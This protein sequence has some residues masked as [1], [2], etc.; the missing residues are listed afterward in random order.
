[1]FHSRL[2]VSH[3]SRYLLS[4]GWLWQPWSC[5]MV[6]DLIAALDNPARLDSCGDAFDMRGLIGAEIAAPAL[7]AMMSS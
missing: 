2:A 1:M 5:V 7:Q 4:A 6:Y 3:S